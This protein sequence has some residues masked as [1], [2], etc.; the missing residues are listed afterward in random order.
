MDGWWM[1]AKGDNHGRSADFVKPMDEAD[2]L[3]VLSQ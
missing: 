2:L 1:V 3:V